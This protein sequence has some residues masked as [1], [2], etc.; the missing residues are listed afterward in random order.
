MKERF[1]LLVFL[2]LN[3]NSIQ[4]QSF[5]YKTY[6]NIANYFASV[7]DMKSF[8]NF[9]NGEV[10]AEIGAGDGQNIGGFGLLVDSCTFYI[11]DIDHKVLNNANWNKL[12]KKYI[13][14]GMS[15]KHQ[16]NLVIGEEKRTNLPRAIFDKIIMSSSFHEFIYMNEMIEDIKTRLKPNGMVYILETHCLTEGHTNYSEN[17]TKVIMA[18]HGFELIGENHTQRNGSE[19]LY[20][21]AF[22]R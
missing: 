21:L 9:Q 19:G 12:Y 5:S 17:E 10:I 4:S 6:G 8:F 7:A 13:K 22:S 11:Q 15:S 3:I 20:M 18:N 16:F 14:A 2:V 1:Y